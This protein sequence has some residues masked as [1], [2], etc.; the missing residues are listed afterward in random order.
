[1]EQSEEALYSHI[2][3]GLDDLDDCTA[4]ERRP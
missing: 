1:M 3:T 4:V 2:S